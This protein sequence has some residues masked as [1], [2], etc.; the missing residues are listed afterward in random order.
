MTSRFWLVHM[1]GRVLHSDHGARERYIDRRHVERLISATFQESIMEH[2]NATPIGG[3]LD[4]FRF[5]K[6]T[7]YAA[8][9]Q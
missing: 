8:V 7:C 4:D 5:W 6:C 9:V 3:I 2:A 1:L